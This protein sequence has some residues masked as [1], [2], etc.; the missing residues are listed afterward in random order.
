MVA[1]PEDRAAGW[2]PDPWSD[3]QHRYWTGA[4]W[5]GDVFPSGPTGPAEATAA[6]AAV[7]SATPDDVAHAAEPP[8][9]PH[10]LSPA[11]SPPPPPPPFEPTETDAAEPPA[12]RSHA[13]RPTALQLVAAAI[14]LVLFV[15][16][17]GLI[18]RRHRATP[19][20]AVPTFTFPRPTTPPATRPADPAAAVLASIVVHQDDVPSTLS[21]D[22]IAGGNQVVGQPTLDLCDG[23]FASE[24]KRTARLQVAANDSQ[25]NA[26]IS[27]E[28]VLYNDSSAT[29]QA[30]NEL[31]SAADGCPTKFNPAPDG[32]WP[33]VAN[34]ERVV[35]DFTSVDT[36]GQSQHYVA[37]YLRRGRALLGVYF[38]Q[39]D[40][41]IPTVAGQNTIAGIV[42][43]FATR[44][45]RL[46]TSAVAD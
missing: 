32:S 46:P 36:F 23:T 13:R 34:V 8:P 9:P 33:Q 44:L 40:A 20:S 30:F 21:V 6:S 3:G 18:T 27:T 42:N 28:A 17:I 38:Q 11:G 39:P 25:D 35:F 19:Q 7:A 15:A 26:V 37:A 45:A 16:T 31:R 2:Y 41:T 1:V 5:T 10:W 12:N 22:T 24:L 43:V 14:A 29:A 4:A